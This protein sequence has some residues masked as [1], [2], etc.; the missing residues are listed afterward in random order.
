M[1][2]VEQPNRRGS[3]INHATNRGGRGQS[4]DQEQVFE[5]VQKPVAA[6]SYRTQVLH[7]CTMV[8]RPAMRLVVWLHNR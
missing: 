4:H 8:A 7:S 6:I 5:H 3:Q 2:P 1:R